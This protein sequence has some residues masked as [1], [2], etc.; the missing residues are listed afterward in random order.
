MYDLF[1]GIDISKETLDTA[2]YDGKPIYIG[3]FPNEV[4]GFKDMVQQLRELTNTDPSKWFICFENSGVYSKA[5]GEWLASQQIVYTEQN[6][7][8]VS[9]SLGIRR[10]KN[11][12][13]DSKDLCRY[14]FEKR[15]SLQPTVLSNPLI[16]KLKRLLS[17]RDLLVRHKTALGVSVSETSQYDEPDIAELFS[18]QNETLIATMSKQIEEIEAEIKKLI[19]SDDDLF[20]NDQLV[21]S[22]IGIGPVISAYILAF[23]GNFTLFSD[24]RKFASYVGVAPFIHNQSG[25]QKGS[26]RVSH[27]ANKKIKSLLGMA[28]KAAI[29]HDPEIGLYYHRMLDKGKEG[30]L[31]INNVKNKVIQRAFAT[32][33]RQSPYVKLMN[34]A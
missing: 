19:K 8:V 1:V 16:K 13:A 34:Y 25:K 28:V 29:Q 31:V 12:K 24:A 2:Y 6:A 10:G 4:D 27:I 17:R 5:L 9:K 33:N 3:Q 26:N 20:R 15:D 32:I 30:G 11:D 22:V 21:Q 7:L 18:S 23:T 14:C